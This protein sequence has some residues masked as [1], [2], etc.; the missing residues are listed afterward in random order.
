MIIHLLPNLW[1]MI[2]LLM[3]LAESSLFRRLNSAYLMLL[4]ARS[5]SN[6]STIIVKFINEGDFNIFLP[7][8]TW[9]TTR[10]DVILTMPSSTFQ[11]QLLS[12]LELTMKVLRLLFHPFCDIKLS[13]HQSNTFKSVCFT[14]TGSATTVVL[15]LMYRPGLA[16]VTDTFF[17]ELTSCLYKC[18]VV[19]AGEFI[20][21][22]ETSDNHDA[23]QLMDVVASFECVHHVPMQPTRR[24][25]ELSTS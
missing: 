7:T 11:D 15:L 2:Q 9:H 23:V 1:V 21:H 5:V 18:Q 24:D 3:S 16:A 14:V 19:V 4:N 12:R 25:G 8:E 20:C 17:N 22:V 10:E 13:H 6:K